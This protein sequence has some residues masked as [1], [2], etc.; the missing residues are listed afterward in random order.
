MKKNELRDNQ[1]SSGDKGRARQQVNAPLSSSIEHM[2]GIGNNIMRT[3]NGLVHACGTWRWKPD[4][5]DKKTVVQWVWGSTLSTEPVYHEENP[6]K[7]F[8]NYALSNFPW[9]F[10]F[11]KNSLRQIAKITDRIKSKNALNHWIN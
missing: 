4:L 7:I 6:R 9:S 11:V 8:M 5:L 2:N 10:Q 3:D 1:W